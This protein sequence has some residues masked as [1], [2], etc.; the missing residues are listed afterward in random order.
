MQLL[1]PGHT[2]SSAADDELCITIL[3]TFLMTAHSE[4]TKAFRK[5]LFRPRVFIDVSKCD[6]STTATRS[7][8]VGTNLH[9]PCRSRK[10][11]QS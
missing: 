2:I 7:T 8:N 9:R 1:E 3:N 4:N 5:V 11:R 10:S 6:T